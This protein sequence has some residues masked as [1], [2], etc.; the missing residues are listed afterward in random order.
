M[1]DKN[2]GKKLEQRVLF[3][4]HVTDLLGYCL[5]PKF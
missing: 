2:E 1:K 3:Y 4:N 5:L